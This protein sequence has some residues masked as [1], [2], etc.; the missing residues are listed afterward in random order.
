MITILGGI[1][2]VS[3]GLLGY[4]SVRSYF[5]FEQVV[6]SNPNEELILFFLIFLTVI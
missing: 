1:V 2:F 5:I 4:N 3:I 6:S